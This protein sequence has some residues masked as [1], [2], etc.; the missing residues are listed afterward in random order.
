MFNS[1]LKSLIA[2]TSLAASVMLLAN[3]NGV[4]AFPVPSSKHLASIDR[5]LQTISLGGLRSAIAE[6]S[7]QGAM[8]QNTDDPP[9]VIIDNDPGSVNPSP[10]RRT[11][12]DTRFSCEITNG[13][14]TVMY[15]P[16]SQPERGYPWAIP[17]QLG[18]G[19][20][21]E[22]RCNEITRRFEAYRAD[23]LLELT[24]DVE[25][26]YDIIC[27]TTQVDP[28]DCRIVF[29]V[30]PGQDP[31]LTRDLVFENLLAADDGQQTDGVYT[32]TDNDSENQ[33]FEGVGKI[34]EDIGI[35]RTSN[36]A[37]KSPEKI[38]LRP[39]LDPADGGTGSQ[40]KQDKAGVSTG[41]P[42]ER[43]PAVFR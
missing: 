3:S 32:L 10:T 12:S 33:I 35:N 5:Y 22:R 41:N 38:D 31:Q 18:G 2:R 21:P 27:V 40:L 42:S 24:T 8:A 13:E 17:S 4:D 36:T 23:G 37:R 1:P 11:S 34:L 6:G 14:Y 15:Y 30:P 19:W 26:N 29:T 39:F 9:E 25:N 20:T 16:E 28:S 43:K 7:A